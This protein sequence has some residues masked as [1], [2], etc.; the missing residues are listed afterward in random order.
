MGCLSVFSHYD[1]DDIYDFIWDPHHYSEWKQVT[2]SL[3]IDPENQNVYQVPS[4][5]MSSTPK[6][7]TNL[8]LWWNSPDE[9]TKYYVYLQFAEIEKLQTN[10][11]RLLSITRNG[12][13]F[14]EPF[15]LLY[16][17]TSTVSMT[18]ALTGAALHNASI[19]HDGN[20]TLP[21]IL[22][23]FE[24]YTVIEFLQEETNQQDV[25][26]IQNI[27]NTYGVKRNWQGD[28]CAPQEYLWEG[29]HCSYNGYEP[30][31]I[32]SFN[33]SSTGLTGEIPPSFSNLT[34]LQ[35]LKLEKN[36]LTGPVPVGLIQ[37][38]NDGS[39]T[40]SLCENQNLNVLLHCEKE[41]KKDSI[42]VPVATSVVGILILL[43]IVAA[44][45]WWRFKNK[46]TMQF[47]VIPLLVPSTDV[48]ADLPP[49]IQ[50]GPME[51]S[52]RQFTYSEV[53]KITNNCERIV[54]RGGFGSVYHGYIGD[55]Q[56][57]VKML[58]QSSVQGY[59]EFHS[60][61]NLLMR[62]HHR[63]LTSLVGY[64]TDGTNTGLIYEYMF[65]GNLHE[66]LSDKLIAEKETTLKRNFNNTLNNLKVHVKAYREINTRPHDNRSNI[67]SWADRLRIAIDAAHENLHV[68]LEYLHYGCKPPIIHRDVKSTNILLNEN[69][70]AKLADFGLSRSFPAE[71][72]TRVWTCVAGTPGCLF[73]FLLYPSSFVCYTKEPAG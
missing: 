56:V 51:P 7:A 14:Q 8:D 9:N 15:P 55:T 64:C 19:S 25:D 71:D 52:Q 63:N 17:S 21:P 42:L 38:S 22:N 72:G 11:T 13:P 27:K 50:H 62:V 29:L 30:P 33:L 6:N 24:I 16:L 45:I 44:V 46:E 5:V 28:P 68:G 4:I 70:Q 10:Q 59:Q 31:R 43:T 53:L 73:A 23:A 54:G 36:N 12:K 20:S 39:L 1:A 65:N 3:T 35:T 58:S 69:F 47:L 67:L 40:L 41:K 61:V 26:F 34:M 60:E 2:T 32:I 49:I 48:T 57:A 18:E 37:K 66:H